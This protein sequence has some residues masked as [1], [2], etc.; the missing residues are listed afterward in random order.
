[1]RRT[2]THNA[3]IASRP[4][5]PPPRRL[6]LRMAWLAVMLAAVGAAAA[7]AVL[8]LTGEGP[9]EPALALP[10]EIVGPDP[11][12]FDETLTSAYERAAAFGLSHV[13]F[14]KSPGGVPASAKRTSGFRS[15]IEEAARGSG[16]GADLL[17]AM[18]FLESAGRPDVIAGD[19]VEHA[20]GLTQIVSE[21]ATSFLGMK[22]DLS[23]S[24]RLTGQIEEARR[25]GERQEA[26][27]LRAERRRVDARFDPARAL[28]GTVRYLTE[29]RRRFGRDDL[30]V[31]SYHMGIGNLESVLRSYS[32]RAGEPIAT[33]VEEDGLDYAQIFFDSSP[34]SRRQAWERLASLGDDSQTYYWRVLAA[35]EIMRLSRERPAELDRLAELHGRRPSAEH[36]LLPPEL[37][38]R[39]ALPSDVER[40]RSAGAV[41]PFCTGPSAACE[42]GPQVGRLAPALSA[43]PYDYRTLRPRAGA[44]LGYLAARVRDLSGAELPLRVTSAVYD[45]AYASRL[46]GGDPQPETHLSVH[47]TGYS[48]DIR[49]RYASG[50]QAEAFQYTLERLEALGLIAWMRGK[51]VIHI[52]VSP[53]AAVEG[54]P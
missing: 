2:S 9:R 17:E 16:F 14:A 53:R 3:E 8:S 34:L 47:T 24:R 21:T 30:A 38:P 10:S 46:A 20:A 28:A 29:A 32:G 33:V 35:G 40:A 41:G 48:F 26:E 19:D 27:R 7:L 18:V 52:T 39:F 36:V 23:A 11:L 42:I 5:T 37:T 25:R 22:V 49:R 45:E 43:D 4:D 31:V 13:V 6:R 12:T 50:A 15:V 51:Q 54:L 1:M 44:L